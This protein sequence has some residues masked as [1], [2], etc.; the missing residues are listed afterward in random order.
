MRTNP[1][2]SWRQSNR[3]PATGFVLWEGP[4]RLNG[5]PVAVV[6]TGLRHPSNN[7]KTGDMLQAWIIPAGEEPPH[8]A[9]KTGSDTAVCGDCKHRPAMGG[10][11]YV[12]A[13][14]AP[15]SVH[16]SYRAG[17][18]P[19]LSTS[20]ARSLLTGALLR[21]GAWGDPAAVPA[22]VWL[23]LT[24]V[25][26]GWSGYTHQW[27]GMSPGERAVWS[28]I[29]M[30]SVDTLPEQLRALSWGWRVFRVH[31]GE[32]PTGL[33]TCPAA[34]ESKAAQRGVKIHCASCLA[35]DGA[36]SRRKSV[37]IRVHGAK[38]KRF[39]GGAV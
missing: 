19:R 2:K 11:C 21:M 14:N 10:A 27:H 4:S 37:A 7:T 33:M 39:G 1:M 9:V 24:G 28:A 5:E 6:V 34:E 31:T 25:L 18:Y 22:S 15:R 20:E 32:R 38:S 8:V 29:V 3:F 13:H 23:D 16:K 26:A 35:C 36:P 17:R 30:A 12:L